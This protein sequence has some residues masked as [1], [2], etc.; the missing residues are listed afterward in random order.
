MG[1]GKKE[2]AISELN[3]WQTT[4]D[5]RIKRRNGQLYARFTKLGIRI[6]QRLHETTL[7][8]AKLACDEIEHII[9][10]NRTL[11]PNEI[12]AKVREHFGGKGSD[13]KTASDANLIGEL[14]PRFIEF[15]K[16][17]SKVHGI[18]KWREKTAHEYDSFWKRS[19]EPFWQYKLPNE[20]ESDW[21]NFIKKE[22]QRSKK[23]DQLTFA[24]HTKY[25]QAFCSYLVLKKIVPVKPKI[26]NPDPD[27]DEDEIDGDGAGIVIPDHV[28]G[29]MLKIASGS[30]GVFVRCAA[31][32]GMRSSEITQMRKD[33]LD[34]A[35][36]VIRLK[37][38]DVKTGSKTGKGRIVPIHSEALPYIREQVRRSGDSP[39]LFPNQR[40]SGRPMDPTGFY[41]QWNAMKEAVGMPGITP[42]DLR[43]T[44]ATKIFSNP[45]VNPVLACKALG[46]TMQTA[47][48][49]YIHFDE[50]HLQIVSTQFTFNQ[51]SEGKNVSGTGLGLEEN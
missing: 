23:G 5:Q 38:R 4:S 36:S 34:F 15:R 31:F 19:F 42:H 25:F 18:K 11:L 47:E 2:N 28:I 13:E 7:A 21:E 6:E 26:W 43:H 51:N 32:M 48:R 12:R 46:M 10:S 22:R 20:I 41:G 16:A 45:N 29:E 1:M 9:T 40:D 30:F 37:A 3:T 33:R 27:I 24:N 50:K 8:A 14:W 44:Y 39:C 49:V 35:S 17:G